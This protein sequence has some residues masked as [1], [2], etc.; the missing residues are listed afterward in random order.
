MDIVVYSSLFSS[1]YVTSTEIKETPVL[2]HLCKAGGCLF[3]ERRNRS[4]LKNEIKEITTALQNN[5]VVTVFPEATS[6]NGQEVLRFRRPLYL[7]AI[8]ASVP[9]VPISISY[10]EIDGQPIDQKSRDDICWY[11]DMPFVDHL[12]RMLS[13]KSIKAK[14]TVSV[15]LDSSLAKDQ[16]DPPG[17]LAKTTHAIVSSTY[18]PI[19]RL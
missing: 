7:S 17:F 15:P 14:V 9:I 13:R 3:V 11:G 5:C 2:G 6:T 4:N 12:L 19:P 18:Q 16:E 1:S 10:Y 8:E